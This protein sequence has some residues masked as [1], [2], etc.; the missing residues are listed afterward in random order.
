MT[1]PARQNPPPAAPAA[2]PQATR[3][4]PQHGPHAPTPP[5]S[6]WQR[7]TLGVLALLLLLAGSGYAL[8]S[9]K[10]A[11]TSPYLAACWRMGVVFGAL[12]LA[13]PQLAGLR[14]LR[15]RLWFG[16][17]VVLVVILWRWPRLLPLAL[18][19][20]LVLA[21]LRPRKPAAR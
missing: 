8:F 6:S 20:L 2:H 19:A 7:H 3:P 12:W 21:L 13:L 18:L 9:A 16:G 15:N 14:L 5:G 17:L 1:Q 10:D 11:Q 4:H